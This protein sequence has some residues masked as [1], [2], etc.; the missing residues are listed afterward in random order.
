MSYQRARLL[1]DLP[2]SL[3]RVRTSRGVFVSDA[4]VEKTLVYSMYL[5]VLKE[6]RSDLSI[7][8]VDI[9]YP[10]ILRYWERYT[11]GHMWRLD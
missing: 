6:V 8:S 5:T 4:M 11:F 10:K 1:P 9:Y 3:Y 7:D 2:T